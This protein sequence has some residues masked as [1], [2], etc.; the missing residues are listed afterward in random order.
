LNE[1]TCTVLVYKYKSLE[2][3]QELPT[4]PANFTGKSTCAAIHVSP[5]GKL[6]AASNRGH[7]SIAVFKTKEN[8]ELDFLTHVMDI[9]EPRDFSFSPDGNWLLAGQQNGDCVTVFKIAN[10]TFTKTSEAGLPKPVCILFGG[11][12]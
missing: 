8:G 4:L 9:K 10:D 12:I 2:L 7:D 1:L 5:D 6:L 11:A 3:L